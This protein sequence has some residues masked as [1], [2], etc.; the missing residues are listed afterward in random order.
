[1]I[2]VTTL[3]RISAGVVQ[4]ISSNRDLILLRGKFFV[5]NI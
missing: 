3:L 2:S 4:K 1:M 5:K